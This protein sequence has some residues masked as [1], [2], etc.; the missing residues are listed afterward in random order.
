[1]ARVDRFSAPD[2]TDR[3][4]TIT[5]EV[6]IPSGG[7][8]GVL[9]QSGARFGG[10]VLY[11]RDGRPVYEYAFSERSG[12]GCVGDATLP[13]GRSTLRYEFTKTGDA[14]GRVRCSSMAGPSGRPSY[15]RPGRRSGSR[16]GSPAGG[17]VRSP[18]SDAYRVPFP[19][20]GTLHRVVVELTDDGGHDLAAEY[21]GALAE[22]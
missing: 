2:I 11:V 8:E 3:S 22:E 14:G 21:E 1:M 5:A 9:L 13:T 19:F 12:S 4:Y 18:I 7:A 10:Y 6:E 20:T 15:R 17:P 16:P